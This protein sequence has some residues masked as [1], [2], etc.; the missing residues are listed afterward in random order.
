MSHYHI[1]ITPKAQK[2]LKKIDRSQLQRLD[3]AIL[4]LELTPFPPGVKR[5][6]ADDVA[7]YRIRIGDYRILYDVD[8]NNKTII[9]LRVGHRKDIYR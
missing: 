3:A 4:K 7:D 8:V 1:L 6:I 9:I 2:E 5:I